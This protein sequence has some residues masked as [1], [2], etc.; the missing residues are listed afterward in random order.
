MIW[1]NW[2][3]L[4][5]ATAGVLSLQVSGPGYRVGLWGFRT[6]IS[7][8]KASAY[9]SVVALVVCLGSLII[10]QPRK[11]SQEMVPADYRL[12]DC[13]WCTWDNAQVEIQSGILWHP[14]PHLCESKPPTRFI[15]LA[16]KMTLSFGSARLQ[17]VVA[18]MCVRS[19][20]W[21]RAMSARM[22]VGSVPI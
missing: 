6:G 2:L 14:N 10:R 12:G 21:A 5:L 22:H 15:G 4:S 7:L 8:V 20:E 3:G 16:L 18:L 1:T 19:R 9:F 17:K 13:N 11:I